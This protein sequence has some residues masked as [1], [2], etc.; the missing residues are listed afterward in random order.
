[1][2]EKTLMAQRTDP[3]SLEERRAAREASL[4]DALS[5]QQ[6]QRVS[7]GRVRYALSQLAQNNIEHV[8]SWLDAVV[9]NEG[10]KVA[11]E[12][13]LKL[14][15]YCV[16]KLSRT[17]VKVEDSA[18]NTAIAQL[19]IADLQ[20]LIRKGVDLEKRTFDSTAEEITPEEITD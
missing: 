1:M 7:T 5:E 15:E 11:L 20:D 3:V 14:I 9:L 13:Y 19:S 2:A 16:P 4:P 12:L 18:G 6:L 8:Q 17:E 10:P